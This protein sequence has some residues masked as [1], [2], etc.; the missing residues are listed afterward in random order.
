M[1]PIE[2]AKCTSRGIPT[3]A[4]LKRISQIFGSRRNNWL[5]NDSDCSIRTT[6]EGDDFDLQKNLIILTGNIF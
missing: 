2:I 3:E 6:F 4:N 1:F 5:K